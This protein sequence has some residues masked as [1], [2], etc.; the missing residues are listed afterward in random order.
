MSAGLKGLLL[1]SAGAS[2]AAPSKVGWL[3][4]LEVLV[5]CNAAMQGLIPMEIGHLSNLFA[6]L[7]SRASA[8][9]S[10]AP[11]LMRLVA[12]LTQ[13]HLREHLLTGKQSCLC[14]GKQL[15]HFCASPGAARRGAGAGQLAASG[16]GLRVSARGVVAGHRG[17]DDAL[18]HHSACCIGT[19][20]A[21]QNDV[22]GMLIT[23]FISAV[24]A[25]VLHDH[26]RTHDNW[27]D[28]RL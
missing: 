26:V 13:L 21:A 8:A 22:A 16:R 17:G 9:G 10:L 14:S 4:L 11:E 19:T 3:A 18:A 25:F 5:T 27:N 20:V 15:Q 1:G 24:T 12:R 2:G 7:V 6:L 23:H 28:L